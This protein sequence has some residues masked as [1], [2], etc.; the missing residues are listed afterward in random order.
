MII[1]SELW[2]LILN[3]CENTF[4]YFF[5]YILGEVCYIW[6]MF[7]TIYGSFNPEIICLKLSL[8]TL[9]LLLIFSFS[10]NSLINFYSSLSKSEPSFEFMIIGSSGVRSYSSRVA[11]IKYSSFYMTDLWAVPVPKSLSSILLDS[12]LFV[13]SIFP[14]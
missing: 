1:G 3:F 11:D 13:S 5:S 6:S 9:F 12:R 8:L 2:W 7:S 4:S 14:S 10:R